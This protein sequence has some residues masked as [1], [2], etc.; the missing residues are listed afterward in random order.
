[1]KYIEVLKNQIN[2]FGGDL[3]RN[4]SNIKGLSKAIAKK[5]NNDEGRVIFL[6]TG[7]SI[8]NLKTLLG[9]LEENFKLDR[10]K[11]IAMENGESYSDYGEL[12]QDVKHLPMTA[13]LDLEEIEL[14]KDDIVIGLSLSSLHGYT[15]RGLMFAKD[16]GCLVG[17]ISDLSKN[18][19]N[20]LDIDF[21]INLIP[22]SNDESLIIG[23]NTPINGLVVSIYTNMI[24]FTALEEMGRIWKGYSVFLDTSQT[25]L[26][27]RA[28]Y[29]ISKILKV[30]RNEAES[31][32]NNNNDLLEVAIVR[33]LKKVNYE[34][35]I[36]ILKENDF[37][38]N[39]I[40]S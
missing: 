22:Q 15:K 34:E 3:E 32:L 33:G 5:Y 14:T 17:A 20:E 19:S 10:S 16:S 12:R 37:D 8:L 31:I 30:D 35:A 2:G 6:G 36:V 25:R 38:F 18:D 11:I 28:I 40:F 9:Q 13:T 23:T 4:Q 26:Y 27:K 1:M 24:I 39:K 21:E 7:L 29:I